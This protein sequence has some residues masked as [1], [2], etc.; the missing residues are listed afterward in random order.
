MIRV[1]IILF[2]FFN[3]KLV[4]AQVPQADFVAPA[5]VCKNELFEL[6]NSSLGDNYEWDFCQGDLQLLPTVQQGVQSTGGTTLGVDIVFDGAVW[7]GFVTDASNNTVIRLSY[8]VD[9]NSTPTTVALGSIF[10]TS[11]VP[12]DIEIV[13]DNGEWF[14]FVYGVGQLITRLNFGDSLANIPTST[15]V[16]SGNGTTS[17]LDVEYMD[18]KWYISFTQN[19]SVTIIELLNI[20]DTPTVE[21]MIT[22]S[23]SDVNVRLGDLKILKLG[24]N[25]YGYSVC[26]S[27]KKLFRFSFGS[28]LFSVADITEISGQTIGSFT[29]FG[30]D[31]AFDNGQFVLFISTLEGNL[32]RIN[33]GVNLDAL[34]LEEVN[35]GNFGILSNTLKIKMVKQ[36][37][38]W[39]AFSISY[40]AGNLFNIY[41]QNPSCTVNQIQSE[42][43]SPQLIFTNSGISI[44]H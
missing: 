8:G 22:T 1:L 21:N 34:P 30:I 32:L 12:Y 42:Q 2:I 27:T 41:F 23:L 15:V 28:Q 35:L 13:Y 31:G 19:F 14:G 11:V 16:L 24:N 33:L 20:T 26:Y 10:S 7:Y 29:P 36:Q 9:L 40:T 3:I 43:E 37:S 17:G 18:G 25:W 4:D 5:S 6:N 38:S 44:F 39:R